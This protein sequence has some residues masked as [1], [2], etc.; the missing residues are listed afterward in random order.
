MVRDSHLAADHH[1]MA[2]R[3]RPGNARLRSNHR[4]R[5]DPHVVAHV[6]EVI[7]LHAFG[8]A[9]VIQRA[10]IDG[11]VRANLH[12]VSDFHDAHLRKFPVATVSVDIPKAPPATNTTRTM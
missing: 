8:D 11:R 10:A 2:E 5:A 9:C 3:T 6:Y 7:D 12:V 1:M 4:V